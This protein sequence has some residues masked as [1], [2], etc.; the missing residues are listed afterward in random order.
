MPIGQRTIAHSGSVAS[1]ETSLEACRG[2]RHGRGWIGA[3]ADE[4]VEYVRG[5]LFRFVQRCDEAVLQRIEAGSD[6]VGRAD[7]VVGPLNVVADG[8]LAQNQLVGDLP[9][10]EPAG[11]QAEDFMFSGGEEVIPPKP[12][13][14]VPGDHTD[15]IDTLGVE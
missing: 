5:F 7:L 8:L 6:P 9:I 12:R 10:R 11:D 1:I 15:G 13:C 14:P 2:Q 4:S 3:P